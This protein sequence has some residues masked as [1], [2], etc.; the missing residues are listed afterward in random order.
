M[1]SLEFCLHVL[2][3]FAEFIIFA[4]AVKERIMF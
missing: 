3:D 2:K 1:L 4:Q